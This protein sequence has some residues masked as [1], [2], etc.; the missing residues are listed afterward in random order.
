MDLWVIRMVGAKII[1][2]DERTVE[3]SLISLPK[4]TIAA[5]QGCFRM[6][7]SVAFHEL[8]AQSPIVQGS[9]LPS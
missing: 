6:G 5:V 3:M 1:R 2:R 4:P 9:L 7:R 8:P